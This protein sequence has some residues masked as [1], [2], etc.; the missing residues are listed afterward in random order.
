MKKNKVGIFGGLFDPI[1]YGHLNSMSTVAERLGLEKVKV[2]PSFRS[3]LRPQT[4]G[5]TPEQRLEMTRLGVTELGK[6]AEVDSVEIDR[7][8][9]S[10]TIDTLR[11]LEKSEP[12][13]RFSLIIG[14]DQFGKFDEWKEY[15][16]IVKR[17]DVVVTSRPGVDFPYSVER[18]PPG[19]RSHVED[20][21][22]KQALL[23]TGR[24]IHFIKLQDVEAS[25]TEIR[26]HVRLGQG[27]HHLVPPPI[28]EYIKENH[29]YESISKNIGD[30][31]K[32]TTFCASHLKE[33]GGIQVRAFDLTEIQAPSEYSVITSGTSTRHST[34]LAE[35]L[36]KEVKKEYGVWPQGIEGTSEGRWVV[37]DYGSLIVHSFY[38]FVRTEYRLEN[39]WK[40]G[41]EI[42]L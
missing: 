36:V 38:D 34:S 29:L 3:P 21:D 26:K 17:V 39:L 37:I 22:G 42:E 31:K 27:I 11:T 24:T 1:H 35:T 28:V 5:A 14:M 15:E 13:T 40:K 2:I 23:K 20:F 6:L 7:G 12:E 16:E 9:T 4:Q 32:F 8:G 18:L 10:Y 30:F 41:V 25:A 33:K 19:L